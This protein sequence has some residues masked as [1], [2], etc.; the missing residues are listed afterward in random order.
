MHLGVILIS[1]LMDIS[2]ANNTVAIVVTAPI[3][4]DI[5]K[6]YDISP[7][8]TAS[9][10]DISTCIA[11]GVIPYGAQILIAADCSRVCPGLLHSDHALSVLPLS[12]AGL[13][14]VRHFYQKKKLKGD[15][16]VLFRNPFHL[17]ILQ[18]F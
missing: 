13:C 3:A 10:M 9:L 7:Q 12:S 15:I 5:R 16:S 14:A 11:Q 6:E 18:H 4:T 1:M 2:T 17:F 8:R